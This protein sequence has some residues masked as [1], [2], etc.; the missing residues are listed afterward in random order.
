MEAIQMVSCTA[1]S[2]EH[3]AE[4]ETQTQIQNQIQKEIQIQI[5]VQPW[6]L[7]K[8]QLSQIIYFK[9][10]SV[11]ILAVFWSKFNKGSLF[12][13]SCLF[14]YS[15]KILWI[16][17]NYGFIGLSGFIQP[18]WF[19]EKKHRK[20]C[21]CCP[22]HSLFKGHKVILLLETPCSLVRWSVTCFTPI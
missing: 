9:P 4:R 18:V 16:K 17:S 1:S 12:I 2:H 3:C 5:Q 19:I 14:S 11:N 10:G 22:R 20:N 8:F 21:E 13:R 6:T 15:K 7:E